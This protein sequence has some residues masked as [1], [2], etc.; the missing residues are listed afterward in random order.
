MTA[1]TLVCFM[2]EVPVSCRKGNFSNLD[3]HMRN[4]HK[5]GDNMVQFSSASLKRFVLFDID[6]FSFVRLSAVTVT[7]WLAALCPRRSGTR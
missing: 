4:T 6:C 1:G 5:V 3:D 2:C 7:C